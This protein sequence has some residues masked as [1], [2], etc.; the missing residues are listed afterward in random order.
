MEHSDMAVAERESTLRHRSERDSCTCSRQV[1]F[2]VEVELEAPDGSL[3]FLKVD[4]HHFQSAASDRRSIT[5][6]PVR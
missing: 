2:E 6:W 5:G 1:K 3:T 4:L